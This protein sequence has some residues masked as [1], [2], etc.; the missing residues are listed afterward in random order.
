MS[1]LTF[2]PSMTK[3]SFGAGSAPFEM[4]ENVI[5]SPG[6]ANLPLSGSGLMSSWCL[7]SLTALVD[8]GCSASVEQ[9]LASCNQLFWPIIFPCIII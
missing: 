7:W 3:E 6:E 2:F 4:H 8:E 5:V 1:E 9:K